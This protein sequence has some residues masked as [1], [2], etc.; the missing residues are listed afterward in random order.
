MNWRRVCYLLTLL[1][2]H[3]SAGHPGHLLS[4]GGALVPGNWPALSLR[5]LLAHVSR[6]LATLPLRHLDLYL[7]ALGPGHQ[8]AL[9][10]H[11]LLGNLPLQLLGHVIAFL[12]DHVTANLLMNLLL[13]MN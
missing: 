12:T 4:H 6:H 2:G 10:L 13:L 5:H 11:H 7:L 3:S 1:P 8:G 9:L